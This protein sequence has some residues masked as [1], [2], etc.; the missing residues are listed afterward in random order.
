MQH[1]VGHAEGV[2]ERRFLVGDAEQVLVRDDDQRVHDIL[3]FLQSGV[4]KAHA[5]HPFEMERF[6]HHAD[7]EDA[8]IPGRPRD[9]RCRAGSGAAAHA[10]GYE[11][12]VAPVQMLGNLIDLFFSRRPADLRPRSGAKALGNIQTELDLPFAFG[13]GEG[14]RVRVRNN[15]HDSFDVGVEHV[16]DCVAA[17]AA[18]AEDDDAR[19]QFGR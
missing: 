2:G 13:L 16:V 6:G 11:H 15:A 7:R 17:G 18:N 14:L 5:L 12:H 9:H 3:Q 10:G 1:L 4:G 8:A 19:S